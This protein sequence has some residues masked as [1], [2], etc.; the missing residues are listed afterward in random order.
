MSWKPRHE[1]HAIERVRVMLPFKD[2]LT[3]KLLN[4]ATKDVVAS[5]D[6]YGFDTVA[7]AKSNVAMINISIPDG[8][9]QTSAAQNGTVLRRHADGNRIEEVG[10]RDGAFGY[11]TST[12]GRWENLRNRLAE[13]VFPALQKV[14]DA[15]D[16]DTIKLEYWDEFRYDGP[17]EEANVDGLLENFDAALPKNVLSG[18]SQWHSHIGWFE[19]NDTGPML[20]NRNFDASDRVTDDGET[21]RILSIYTMVEQRAQS[22]IPI[23]QA[24]EILDRLHNRSLLLFGSSLSKV[25][26]DMIGINLDD[27]Q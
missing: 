19:S 13:V 4:S 5:S 12:Y 27:Y 14:K 20:I 21:S 22:G 23:D 7:P 17:A 6:A 2:P 11:L 8:S 10:F 18:G 3:T 16:L 1:A 9:S 24:H 15:A 26:R 25:Y